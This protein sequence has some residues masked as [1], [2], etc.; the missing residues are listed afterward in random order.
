MYVNLVLN[1]R[2]SIIIFG[3]LAG[4]ERIGRSLSSGNSLKEAQFINSSLSALGDVVAALGRRSTHIP[5][6]NSKLT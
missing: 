3:D 6:R 5:F 1:G 2:H 4:S